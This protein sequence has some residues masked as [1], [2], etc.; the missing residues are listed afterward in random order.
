[1]AGLTVL[2]RLVQQLLGMR[3]LLLLRVGGGLGEGFRRHGIALGLRL[4]IAGLVSKEMQAPSQRVTGMFNEGASAASDNLRWLRLDEGHRSTSTAA[5][6][7]AT[8]S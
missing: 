6:I 4:G 7:C 5:V 2:D 1:M 3:L 8:T